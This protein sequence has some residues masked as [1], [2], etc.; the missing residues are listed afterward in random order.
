MVN[1]IARGGGGKGAGK[2]VGKGV[3]KGAGNHGL[4]GG[5][6]ARHVMKPGH[7]TRPANKPVAPPVG[8]AQNMASRPSAKPFT[9]A[10]QP[11][12]PRQT[13]QLKPQFTGVSQPQQQ[14][15]PR[16]FV[17]RKPLQKP[18]VSGNLT[19]TP[20]LK[21][22]FHQKT[23]QKPVPH[24][25]PIFQKP[26]QQQAQRQ[27][28][29][30]GQRQVQ[31]PAIGQVK[32]LQK[33][34]QHRQQ[35]RQN[36]TFHQKQVAPMQEKSAMPQNKHQADRNRQ[37]FKTA[38]G[39]A[40]GPGERRWSDVTKP[41]P[42]LQKRFSGVVARS[43]PGVTGHPQVHRA[44]AQKADHQ[45]KR[46]AP[47]P[48]SAKVAP[49]NLMH[50]K[51]PVLGPKMAPQAQQRIPSRPEMKNK[52]VPGAKLENRV[53]KRMGKPMLRTAVQVKHEKTSGIYKAPASQKPR[54]FIQRKDDAASAGSAQSPVAKAEMPKGPDSLVTRFAPRQDGIANSKS[55][56]WKMPT[57]LQKPVGDSPKTLNP[58]IK[59][60]GGVPVKKTMTKIAFPS[61]SM[62]VKKNAPQL[63]KRIGNHAPQMKK[64]VVTSNLIGQKSSNNPPQAPSKKLPRLNN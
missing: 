39:P 35:Q 38:T 46:F 27:N 14:S 7:V 5:G 2:G 28:S 18:F 6:Q 62:P 9:R 37:S 45:V 43:K 33:P 41:I 29:M 60:F 51:M 32:P 59:S 12:L 20:M 56:V 22:Q 11:Q 44:G 63:P 40:T 54:T 55:S 48:Q 16:H 23:V 19:H 42:Q 49:S 4:T 17:Q 47:K 61:A 53:I 25:T 13:Q 10:T 34:M 26:V 50:T 30:F 8:L 21:P 57:G 31:K 24:G 52:I 15:Q 36:E 1:I 3:G 64:P 58:P